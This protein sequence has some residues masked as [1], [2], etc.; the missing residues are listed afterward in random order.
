MPEEEGIYELSPEE[1]EA[2]EEGIV[3]LE[4]GQ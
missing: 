1:I 4:N 2:T 3:Q